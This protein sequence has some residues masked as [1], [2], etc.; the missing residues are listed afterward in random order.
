MRS[1]V[2]SFVTSCNLVRGY[3]RFGRPY[4]LSLQV[5][6]IYVQEIAQFHLKAARMM[7]KACS[8]ETSV[9]A[10]TTL[11]TKIIY[12]RYISGNGI[13]QSV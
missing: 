6:S 1:E 11:K 2:I 4:F 8:A 7:G 9:C 13:A 10:S 3:G 12:Y 5:R